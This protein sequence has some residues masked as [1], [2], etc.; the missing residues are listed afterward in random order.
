M[1]LGTTSKALPLLLRSRLLV[2]VNPPLFFLF[3]FSL[4]LIIHNGDHPLSEPFPLFLQGQ[5]EWPVALYGRDFYDVV[6]AVW[7]P[8]VPLSL[9]TGA[10]IAPRKA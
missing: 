10:T 5:K 8:P 6:R 9:V 7:R 1:G 4:L 2:Q 3:Y